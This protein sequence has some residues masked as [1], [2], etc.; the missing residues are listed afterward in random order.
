MNAIEVG[1]LGV[2]VESSGVAILAF[3]PSLSE[4]FLSHFTNTMTQFMAAIVPFV[5][6]IDSTTLS[7]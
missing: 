7:K 1:S 2:F 3:F 6:T 4:S 5:S